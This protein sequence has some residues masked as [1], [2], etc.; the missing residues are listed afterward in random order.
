MFHGLLAPFILVANLAAAAEQPPSADDAG[1]AAVLRQTADEIMSALE[2]E[3]GSG[4][5]APLR[6]RM[7]TLL[8]ERVAY[9]R[10]ARGVVGG[11]RDTLTEKQ[12]Q[13]FTEVFRRS[14]VRLYA[15]ALVA[16]GAGRV[17]V[18]GADVE[19]RRA[20]VNMTVE[21]E[22]GESFELIYSMADPGD[23]WKVLN[24]LIDGMNLGMTYRN[25]FASLMERHDGNVDL[26]ID[27]WMQAARDASTPETKAR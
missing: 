3:Q 24:I 18:A 9:E 5:G 21:T 15:E 10:I 8:D 25:Q 22:D 11:Y 26:V 23:G 12:L 4:D 1:P 19:G 14:L 13:R 20:R 17:T 7:A 2:Q 16:M 6:E 27:N